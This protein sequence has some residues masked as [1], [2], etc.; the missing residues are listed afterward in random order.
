[1]LLAYLRYDPLVRIELGP[2]SISPHGIGIAVGFL[3]GSF[4]FL[5][6][7]RQAGLTDDQVYSRVDRGWLHR[8]SAG[9]F[10]GE[11]V[12]E[13]YADSR[14]LSNSSNGQ[15]APSANCQRG[16]SRSSRPA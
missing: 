8:T 9:V 5:K 14:P 4:F 11:K 3:L 15:P 2:L 10:A 16:A 13:Y 12:Y 1:M 6:W 7:C